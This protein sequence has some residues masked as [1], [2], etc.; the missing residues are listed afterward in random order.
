MAC[1][2]CPGAPDHRGSRAKRFVTADR[3]AGRC[4]KQVKATAHLTMPDRETPNCPPPSAE[5][6]PLT[7][8][9]AESRN[10]TPP[11]AV[12]PEHKVPGFRA[13]SPGVAA[14]PS[15]CRVV[16]PPAGVGGRGV[17]GTGIWGTPVPGSRT[18]GYRESRHAGTGIWGT[19][20]RPGTGS[21]GTLCRA[22]PLPP[23]GNGS[24]NPVVLNSSINS[25]TPGAR[26]AVRS[27]R[28]KRKE[29]RD[30]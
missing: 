29:D 21:P 23:F 8:G 22:N 24:G 15:W 14:R 26:T 9:R 17:S 19:A 25:T 1:L 11:V 12:V 7:V 10:S 13:R 16:E 18:P 28:G 5:T 6:F 20:R 4:C 30:Q 3:R 27:G 2:R